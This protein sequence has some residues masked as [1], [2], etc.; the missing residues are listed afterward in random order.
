VRGPFR[1]FSTGLTWPHAHILT[2]LTRLES[3]LRH[4][5]CG[6][7]FGSDPGTTLRIQIPGHTLMSQRSRSTQFATT[8]AWRSVNTGSSGSQA[9][10]F[11]LSTR[12]ADPPREMGVSANGQVGPRCRAVDHCFTRVVNRLL[13]L[14]APVGTEV[15]DSATRREGWHDE[16]DRFR[17]VRIDRSAWRK[18]ERVN[19]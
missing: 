14:Q 4:A 15:G 3:H 16:I 13:W 6:A 2:S 18:R 8:S 11:C 5:Q 19:D 12:L 10:A 1:P 9:G 7:L 17:S